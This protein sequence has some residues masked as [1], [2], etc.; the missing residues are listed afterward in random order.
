MESAFRGSTPE[1]S[2]FSSWPFHF[3]LKWPFKGR[4]LSVDFLAREGIRWK[5]IIRSN[6]SVND[7][8]V[9]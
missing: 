7:S 8:V 3:G 4:N 5:Q 1:S 2:V 9:R 6:Y